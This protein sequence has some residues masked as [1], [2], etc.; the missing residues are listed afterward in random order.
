M[1]KNNIFNDDVIR[2][3]KNTDNK[4]DLIIAD[5]PYNQGID[6]W[7]KF[8][9]KDYWLFMQ[10]WIKESSKLLNK[11]GSIWIFNNPLNSAKTIPLLEKNNLTFQNWITWYKKDGF[12]APKTKFRTMQ[13]TILFFTN[14]QK[15]SDFNFDIVRVPYKSKERM[16][17]AKTK[18]IVKNGKRWFPNENGALRSDVWEF[19]SHRHNTKING[20]LI[21]QL[22]STP[23]PEAL[24]KTI[25]KTHFKKDMH[26]LDLFSGSGTTS[27]VCRNMNINSDGVELN[28]DYYEVIKEKLNV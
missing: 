8:D 24:I 10:D 17:A 13:E 27:V 28:K 15:P 19:S 20:K 9:E 23:K 14:G 3:M 11:G 18:G 1:S 12:G 22:H 25:I 21:K 26:V 4:Y 2:W 16:E 7:D 5:P 6:S